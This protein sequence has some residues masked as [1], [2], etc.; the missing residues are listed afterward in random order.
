[1][2]LHGIIV[3]G[4][5]N[6]STLSNLTSTLNTYRQS[7]GRSDGHSAGFRTA[8]N[9]N[10]ELTVGYRGWWDVSWGLSANRI[11]A[12]FVCGGAIGSTFWG[13]DGS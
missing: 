7:E 3:K 2:L 1:M 11:A 10:R 5:H 13:G 9:S 12:L 6:N 8:A 4:K